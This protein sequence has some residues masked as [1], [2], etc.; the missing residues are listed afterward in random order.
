M[1]RFARI[2]FSW[3][4]FAA[5]V[6][7]ILFSGTHSTPYQYCAANYEQPY[8]TNQASNFNKSI[9]VGY[10][11]PRFL[12]CEETF[13]NENSGTFLFVVTGLLVWVAARQLITTRAQ[14]RAY[15]LPDNMTLFDGSILNPQI[16]QRFG[17]PG[18]YMLLKNSGQ[19]PAYRVVSWAKIDIIEMGK[20]D[21]LIVPPL[22]ETFTNTVGPNSIST[23]LIWF[24]RPLTAAEIADI[25]QQKKAIYVYGRAEYRDI[26]LKRHYTNFRLGYAGQ[27][28]PSK[29]GGTFNFGVTGNDSN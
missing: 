13:L 5:A 15:L 2:F 11:L 1:L 27:F 29:S 25:G 8:S 24:G 10:Q 21:S 26:F 17:D 22:S 7:V 20:E 16:Q 6:S 18:V 28:P 9:F 3:A 19:T 12:E 23:K 14:L 4:L